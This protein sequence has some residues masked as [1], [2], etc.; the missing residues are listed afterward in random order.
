MKHKLFLVPLSIATIFAFGTV[1]AQSSKTIIQDYYQK[2]AQLTQKNNFNSKLGFIILNEDISKSLGV[3]IVNVQQTYDGLRVYNALGKVLIKDNKIISEKNDFK[4]EIS[5]A[6]QGVA[7]DK[8]SEETLKQNLG[9]QAIAK[10]DYLPNV[11]FEKNNVYVLSKELFVSDK[12]SSD[13]WHV[14]A[15]ANSGEILSKDNLTVQCNFNH[16][17]Q[18]T[19][20]ENTEFQNKKNLQNSSGLNASLLLTPS[21]ASYNIFALPTEAPTFGGRSVLNNP[22]DI[23]ASP[24][25]WHSDGI[26]NYT[27]TRGN[28]VYAYSDQGNTNTPGYSPNGGAGLNFDFPYAEGRYI[29]P[30]THKDA[31]ITNLFY[32]NN[33][34]HDTFYKFGFTEVSRNFQTNNFGNGGIGGDAVNAEAFDGSGLNNANFSPGYETEISGTTYILA[35]RMQ[36]Y[37][38]DRAQTAADPISRYTYNSPSNIASRPKVMATNATFGPILFE[39]Q[40]VTGN[41]A[42]ATPANACTTVAAGSMTGKIGLVNAAGC[43]FS[44]KTKNLQ[45]AGAIGVIQYH[46]SSDTPI[47]LGGTDATITIPT[48]MIGK[49]EGEYLVSQITAGT[50]IN[51]TLSTDFSGFR[52]SSLDNGV[53]VHEYGHGISNRLTG[54]G[55]SCL[56]ASN[57]V[58]QMGEGWSDFFAL[59]LTSL[60]GSTSSLARGMATYSASQAITGVGIRPAKYSPDFSVNNYTYGSTNSMTD[61]HSIGFVWATM[62]WDLTW[63]YVEKYGYN[64]D[65]LANPNSG[66]ARILQMVMNGLKLQACSPTFIDG[67]DAILQADLVGNAGEDKCMIWKA[68]AKRGLG[69]N[70]SAGSKTVITDQVEDFTI[71]TECNVLATEETAVSNTKYVVFPNPTYDEFFVGNID[72]SKEEVNI[73]LFDMSGKLV[74]TDT[75]ENTSKKAISTKGLQKGVYMVH[76]KQGEKIQTEKLIIK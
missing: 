19:D 54:Q 63:K 52:H 41:L 30:F 39:G 11:Y 61:S 23:T 18:N 59:M 27:N 70:A 47:T 12:N 55:Y 24:E 69:A 32:L 4:R 45:N 29:N 50:I 17:S 65:V 20:S 5:I 48:I 2:N 68:F 28:N 25:G 3:N 74:L 22:W 53:V 57:S 33:K 42:I 9:L 6:N 66:N 43:N 10:V 60:P 16:D 14:I 8:F 7:K 35:P 13:V 56:S 49:T 31:A 73:K 38:W 37:L 72:K 71:P 36:M 46:P 62:L 40:S 1:N 76:I 21:P 67:R 64:N 26:N 44:V 51:T 75:R 58:E 34:I 15:D